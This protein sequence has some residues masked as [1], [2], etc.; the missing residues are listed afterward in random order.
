VNFDL[1]NVD[2]MLTYDLD[3]QWGADAYQGTW[4]AYKSEGY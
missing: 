4:L 1:E 2:Q 3:F